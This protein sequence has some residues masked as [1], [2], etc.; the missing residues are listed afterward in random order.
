MKYVLDTIPDEVLK[1]KVFKYRVMIT[2]QPYDLGH[3]YYGLYVY[4][5]LI[6]PSFVGDSMSQLLRYVEIPPEVKFGNQIVLSY[7]DTH[8]IP[9]Y[10]NEFGSI[11][12]DIKDE[13]GNHFPFEFGR[14]IIILHFRKINKY[15]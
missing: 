13:Y 5:D 2:H 1:N 15:S 12:I 6:S 9:V 10:Q 11:E 14:S 8:Y 3:V 4:C 7:P